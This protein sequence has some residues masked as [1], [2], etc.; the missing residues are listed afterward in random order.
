MPSWPDP[1][2]G[3]SYN[4]DCL[5]ALAVVFVFIGHALQTWHVERIAGFVTV[6]SMA[7]TGVLI[8]FVHTS[9]VLM[10]SLDR[11]DGAGGRS[12]VSF[13]IRRAFRIYPAA[14]VI[15]VVSA[16]GQV[17]PFPTVAYARP[18]WTTLLSNIGLV[19]NLTH[20]PSLY[21]PLWSLPYEVQMYVALPFI[22][23]FLKKHRQRK[24]TSLIVWMAAAC[25]LVALT[26]MRVRGISQLA[27]V[28]FFLAGAVAYQRWSG[29]RRRFPFRTWPLAIIGCVALRSAIAAVASPHA[30][31]PAGWMVCLLL[32]FALPLFEEI[33]T[34]WLQVAVA[35]IAKYSYGIYLTHAIVLWLAFV[36]AREAPAVLRVVIW[37]IGSIGGPIVL[38]RFVEGPM[39]E[40]GAQIARSMTK[41]ARPVGR[42]AAAA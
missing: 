32:G 17:P 28:P 36:V 39:I 16:L 4:L 6:Y 18:T 12:Y 35:S 19:Q 9:L 33:P 42:C 11:Q 25:S 7:Q 29:C 40:V 34:R 22:F 41:A 3:K 20:A 31:L 27:Y 24:W 38:Y 15:V 13:Y 14:I 37:S 21:A 23:A 2:N 30:A 5:R 8:F 10:L 1:G 26:A